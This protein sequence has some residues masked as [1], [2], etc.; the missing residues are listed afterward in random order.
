MRPAGDYSISGVNLEGS[1]PDGIRSGYDQGT[2][3][4]QGYTH[5][6]AR[7]LTNETCRNMSI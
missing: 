6:C 4:E 2:K 1:G 5:E 7:V 3:Q